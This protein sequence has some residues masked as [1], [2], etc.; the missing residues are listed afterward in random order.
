MKIAQSTI[1]PPFYRVN[2]NDIF[3]IDV[4]NTVEETDEDES[5]I[6]EYAEYK[7]NIEMDDIDE[8]I[9]NNYDAVLNFAKDK[10]ADS[11]KIVVDD[12]ILTEARIMNI[13]FDIKSIKEKIK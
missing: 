1:K 12:A 6:Y 7:I 3:I 2:G 13:E 11:L 10:Y 8:Y 9:I 5:I 4:A